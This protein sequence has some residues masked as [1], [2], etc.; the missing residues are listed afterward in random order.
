MPFTFDTETDLAIYNGSIC[1]E[2]VTP[3]KIEEGTRITNESRSWEHIVNKRDKRIKLTSKSGRVELEVIKSKIPEV[4]PRTVDGYHFPTYLDEVGIRGSVPAEACQNERV[5]VANLVATSE[6]REPSIVPSGFNISFS[7]ENAWV[8]NGSCDLILTDDYGYR[9]CPTTGLSC[10]IHIASRTHVLKNIM[11]AELAA[12]E[13]LREEISE[14]D[15]RKYLKDGFLL[16]K[17]QSGRIYQIYRDQAHIRVWEHGNR[18][19]EICVYLKDIKIP[20]TDKILAFKIMIETDEDAF[21]KLGNVYN[22]RKAA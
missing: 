14:K 8:K 2:Q 9:A 1:V 10:S 19:E 12:V 21:K 16:V 17:G 22:M 4:R 6:P 20:R 7:G 5:S 15:F 13:N 18:I 3:L 11:G